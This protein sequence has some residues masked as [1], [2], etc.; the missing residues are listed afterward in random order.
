MALK[1]GEGRRVRILMLVENCPYLRD[2]RVQREAKTLAAA[3]YKV[4][5]VAPKGDKS[6]RGREIVDGVSVY[7][8]AKL[9][10][11]STVIGHLLEYFFAMLTIAI[12]SA[13]VFVR[14][15]FDIIHVANPPDTL[16][17]IAS[18]YKIF[19]K[20][21][22]YDQHDL[23]PELYAVKF[24]HS[25]DLIAKIL[26]SL[27]R[28]SYTLADS[29]IVTNES[30]RRQAMA[31]GR[32]PSSRITIVRNGPD[33][34]NARNGEIDPE[35]RGKAPNILAFGGMIEVQDG[36]EELIRAL[37]ALRYKLR[38]DD[39]V[40]IVM[41]SGHALADA[42]G[43]TGSLGLED[44]VW[45]T[46]WI[47]DRE[48]YKRY[49]ASSDICVSPEPSSPYN[50]QSTFVKVMEYMAA[51]RPIV[52]FDLCETR[53]SAQESALYAKCNDEV[54][55]ALAIAKLMDD[56]KLRCQMAQTG[57]K[58]VLEKLAWQYSAPSLLQV[59]E[60]LAGRYKSSAGRSP[61]I[62]ANE[63]ESLRPLCPAKDSQGGKRACGLQRGKQ[64]SLDREL[65]PTVV[66]HAPQTP[67]AYPA[68][69]VVPQSVQVLKRW[70]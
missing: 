43:L 53:F 19:G 37:H 33:L 46:G 38:R 6:V 3:G 59:Y 5:V 23:C 44:N 26:R 20:S 18:V 29:V 60:R 36:V 21:V 15:G 27:E 52:A 70:H 58:L 35:V 30:Y 51:G 65:L 67:I 25:N 34:E 28:F 12:M 4:T 14:E 68:E 57:Q 7:R 55:F 24:G 31:R 32:L 63:E 50:E 39:F 8:F 13:Y 49:L 56:P 64:P 41:G 11:S 61:V 2:P 10:S 47:S 17:F 48:L 54:E 9:K 62:S 1:R 22:I 66:A 45:F 42:K 16:I 69:G 40:C